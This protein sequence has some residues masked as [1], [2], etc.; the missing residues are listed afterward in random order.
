MFFTAEAI[1][2]WF[3]KSGSLIVIQP[4]V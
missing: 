1:K 2:R 3:I 4:F